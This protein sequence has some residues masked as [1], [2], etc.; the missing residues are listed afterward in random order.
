MRGT[1]LSNSVSDGIGDGNYL[2]HEK[3][4]SCLGYIVDY[5]TQL[6]GDYNK[7]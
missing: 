4:P 7:P 2:S 5:A 3:N 1:C 6:Y